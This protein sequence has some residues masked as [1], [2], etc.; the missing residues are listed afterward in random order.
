M[1]RVL[2]AVVI[3]V[4]AALLSAIPA[5]AAFPGKNG[6]IAFAAFSQTGG[7]SN[8]FTIEPDGSGIAPLP[9][10]ELPR[11]SF[12][13]WSPD[14]IHI[15]F[16]SRAAGASG[17]ADIYVQRADGSDQ[18]RL[19]DDPADD[20]YPSW[21]PDGTKIVFASRRGGSTFDLYVM[22]ADGTDETQVTD[23]ARDEWQPAWAPDGEKIA[24]THEYTTE[25]QLFTSIFLI[26]PDGS[27]LSELRTGHSSQDSDPNW[28]PTGSQITF[29]SNRDDGNA[30]VYVM[31]RD[32]TNQTRLTNDPGLDISPAWSPD[33][34]KIIFS[35]A[36][37]GNF[38][39]INLFT[40]NP[41]GSGKSQLT[42]TSTGNGHELADWQPI[43]INAYPRPKGATPAQFSLVPAYAQCTAPN[44]THGPPLAFPSCASPA[45]TSDELTVGTA[46]SNGKPAKSRGVVLYDAFVG[47]PATP[48]DEADVRITVELFD[49]YRRGSLADYTGDLRVRADL[50]ITDKLNN[51]HPGRAGRGNRVRCA[52]WRERAV[53]RHRRPHRGRELQPHHD[54]R[55]THARRGTGVEALDLG[56]RPDPSGRRRRGR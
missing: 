12:P 47:S 44:R 24:F 1:S 33:G 25:I 19:T 28:S 35:H 45:Q 56:A 10:G 36:D 30:E 18:H 11:S 29:W 21:S 5:H 16:A 50:R 31:D 17:G 15:A 40:M 38:P 39:P 46:D 54:L 2:T 48:A 20:T 55:R 4:I 6:K 26:N 42:T 43:P 49:I 14:G 53:C 37:G 7:S 27:G 9:V 51:P 52:A 3:G 8:V 22:N 34:T 32:G 41:D 23:L 13:A